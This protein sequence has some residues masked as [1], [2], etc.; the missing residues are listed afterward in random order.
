MPTA[1]AR[2]TPNSTVSKEKIIK[3][4]MAELMEKGLTNWTVD[5]ISKRAECAKGLIIYHF[6]SKTRLLKLVAE[7][8]RYEHATRL[9]ASLKRSGADALDDLWDAMAEEVRSGNFSMWLALLAD[10][11]TS[12]SA[13]ID[14]PSRHH[15]VTSIASALGIGGEPIE[16]QQVPM[17]LDGLQIQLLVGTTSAAS[18]REQYDSFWLQLLNA[19]E[20]G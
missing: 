7:Q 12:S 17:F 8:V 6:Q 10:R 15:L 19:P 4:G 2:A 14:A 13:T 3:A 18:L 16:L 11:Q 5:Q 9:S 1:R 20:A